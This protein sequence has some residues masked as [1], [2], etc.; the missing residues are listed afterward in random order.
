MPEKHLAEV[1]RSFFL[2]D[3]NALQSHSFI[4]FSMFASSLLDNVDG[5]PFGDAPAIL[6]DPRVDLADCLHNSRI[7]FRAANLIDG[8]LLALW[9]ATA[10]RWQHLGNQYSE[11]QQ[12]KEAEARE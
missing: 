10:Q 5:N 1:R 4:L 7:V 11:E 8:G 2:D 3:K 12:S 9:L 6:S